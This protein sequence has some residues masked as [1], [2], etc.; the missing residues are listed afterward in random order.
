MDEFY[1]NGI[2]YIRFISSCPVC[3]ELS[4]INTPKSYWMHEECHG[5]IYIA[6]NATLYCK[7]CD[8]KVSIENAV[9]LCPNH[10]S[11]PNDNLIRFGGVGRRVINKE[12]IL[13]SLNLSSIPKEWILR[14]A[15]CLIHN[16]YNGFNQHR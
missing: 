7:H 5:D 4:G 8:K 3:L 9:F 11:T 16:A 1:Q 13:E 6:D 15:K 12:S 2:H 14:L 10:N